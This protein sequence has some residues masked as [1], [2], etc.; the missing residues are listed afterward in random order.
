VDFRFFFVSAA[1]SFPSKKAPVALEYVPF[2]FIF[3]LA[4]SIRVNSAGRFQG[5][6]AC[7]PTSTATF[8]A[9][10]GACTWARWSPAWCS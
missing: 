4:N 3:Y 10:P 7:S 1:A 5:Q 2:F 6:K 9:P 8:S